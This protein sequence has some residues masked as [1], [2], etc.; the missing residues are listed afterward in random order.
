MSD[1]LRLGHLI[2]GPA[3][4]DA[5]HIAVA[6][7]IADDRLF[8]GQPVGFI[9]GS[10]D[11]VG[12]SKS[13]VGIVDPFLMAPV[14]KESRV[15]LFLFPGSITSLRHD[16]THPAFSGDTAPAIVLPADTKVSE[17][18]RAELDIAEAEIIRLRDVV[19]LA[20]EEDDDDAQCREMG[21]SA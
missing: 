13:P 8:P 16:W 12:V 3:A 7:V 18:L 2:T 10:K 11:R 9:D 20:K 17:R 6:P 19:A 21:C 5:V 1:T 4:R 14:Y 15:W